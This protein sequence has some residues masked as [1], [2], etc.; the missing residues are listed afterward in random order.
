MLRELTIFNPDVQ[1]NQK[2]I[3]PEMANI[4]DG[5]PSTRYK[6]NFMECTWNIHSKIIIY[7]LNKNRGSD[8][9]NKMAGTKLQRIVKTELESVEVQNASL[10]THICSLHCELTVEYT[11]IKYQK[12]LES[13]TSK[14]RGS[15][16]GTA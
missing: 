11:R 1:I 12:W 7:G 9:D 2:K 8:K 16:W 14:T 10:Y 6:G 13:T 4:G 15:G 5:A 3:F